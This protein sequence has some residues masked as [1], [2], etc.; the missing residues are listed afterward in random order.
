MRNQVSGL[1]PQEIIERVKAAGIV[2]AGGAGFPTHVK[3]NTSV[4]TVIANG[5]ECEPMLCA[6]QHVMERYPGEVVAGL[7][8]AMTAG[9]AERGII[10]LKREYE[11]AVDA[12]TK[13]I[14]GQSDLELFLMDSF[15]PAGD[16]YILVFDAVG[17]LVPEGGI[18]LEVGVVVQNV[19]T[20][21]QIA[22]AMNG[23]PVTHRYV[24]VA[25]EVERPCTLRVPIGSSLSQVI[26]WAG[27][28]AFQTSEVWNA[29]TVVMGGPMMGK[30]A[31]DLSAPV[32][33]TTSGLLVLPKDNVVVRY[34]SRPRDRWVVRGGAT[35][36]QCRDC[37]VL[38][39]RYLLGHNFRPHEIMR[40]IGYGL[41]DHPEFVTAAILCCECRLCEAYACP[42]ELSPM[43]FYVKIKEE[44]GAAGWRNE[45]HRRSEFDPHSYR[46]YRRVPMRRLFARLDLTRYEHSP[47]PL[48]ERQLRPE[49]VSIPL[50]QHIGAPALPIVEVEQ[51][52]DAGDVI[53]A[54]PDGKLGSAIHASIGGVV[55]RVDSGFIG[56]V[57]K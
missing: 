35:C 5:A 56:I 52:V 44:L 24:T 30:L 16:E 47:N 54:I 40:V 2:G 27:G 33:K 29:L 18:P 37:T 42:L 43:T 51:E 39:P 55:E 7:R 9:G 38:C 57:V 45:A 12:L 41:S 8:L 25:G 19:G 1:T 10:A 46:D 31:E 17:R 6:D 50:Q 21:L 3:L 32:T 28:P 36:D 34:M 14:A 48:D 53:G 20:L 26:E 15:Y 11:A 49:S 22:H 23:E 13:A 4:D